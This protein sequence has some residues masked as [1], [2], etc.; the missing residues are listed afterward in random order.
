MKH[1]IVLAVVLF[2]SYTSIFAQN[3]DAVK[4]VWLNNEKNAKLEVYK[5][6]NSYFGKIIWSKDMFEADGKTSKKDINNSNEKL[7]SR[8]LLNLNILSGLTYDDGEWT[9]GELY[10][11]KSGKTYKSKMKLKGGN[12]EIRGY[13]GSPMFGKTMVWTRVS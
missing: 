5:S 1:F 6:G 10:D 9:G 12:L 3:G 13:V 11:P 7:R 2:T 8:N 4:G